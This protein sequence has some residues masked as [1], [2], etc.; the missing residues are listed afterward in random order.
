MI[1]Y[2]SNKESG[3]ER[4]WQECLLME[5]SCVL[6]NGYLCPR[7]CQMCHTGMSYDRSMK[8]LMEKIPHF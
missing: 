1:A 8:A 4:G 5:M 7:G 2:I 6:Q 3:Q